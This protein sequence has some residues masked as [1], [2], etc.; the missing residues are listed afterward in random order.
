MM[1]HPVLMTLALLNLAIALLGRA[2]PLAAVPW[3]PFAFVA[4]TILAGLALER[5][6]AGVS[7][8]RRFR[9]LRP[10]IFPL[11]HLGRDIAWV[12]AIALWLTRRAL[13]RPASPA[14][15][16]RARET[17]IP[18]DECGATLQGATESSQPVVAP[19]D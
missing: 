18:R 2:A 12:A 14:H 1:L 10:L 9:D 7:A 6:V 19:S 17:T 8:A 13:G 4:A 16:M 5:L 15:S 11:L 3:R